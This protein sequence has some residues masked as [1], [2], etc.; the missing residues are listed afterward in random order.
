MAIMTWNEEYSVGVKE[1]DKQHQILFDTINEL[2]R[3]FA[4]KKFSTTDPDIV[5][6]KLGDYGEK[7]FKTEEHFFT[8]FN[9]EKKTEH[10]ILHQKYKTKL[11]ELQTK[12]WMNRDE[13][14][15]FEIINFLQDWWIWHVNNVDKE[16][17]QCF[18]DH[19]L[20]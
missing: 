17:S 3:L 12:Y 2:F 9:Y 18:K 14:I 20:T 13:K 16:Y 10:I 1:I 7:H 6:D 5:F 11:K 15:F 19:G 8:L 4:D